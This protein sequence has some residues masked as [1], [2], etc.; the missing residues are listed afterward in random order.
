MVI[1]AVDDLLFSSKIRTVARQLGVE[2]VFARTPEA[3]LA[4]TRER[5]PSLVILDLN[6]ER[7][8]PLDTLRR[9]AADP[10]LRDTRTIGFVSHVQ[11][12]LIDAAREAGASQVMPRSA[13][14]ASLADI[15]ATHK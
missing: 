3:I 6:G 15:L 4:E 2:V 5:R 11:T 7:M 13:F 9:L 12:A 10:E 8:A 1:A 14:A